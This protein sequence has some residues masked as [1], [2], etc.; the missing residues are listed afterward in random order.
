LL[1]ALLAVPLVDR[2]SAIKAYALREHD[3]A[4]R[5]GLFFRKTIMLA[6]NRVQHIEISSGPLQR[7]FGLASLK[8]Y[9]AGGSS[10]DLKMDGLTSQTAKQLR[11]HIMQRSVGLEHA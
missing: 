10:V 11:S 6:F 1:A 7:R 9:T 8:F 5:S 3:I 4:Y 2:A